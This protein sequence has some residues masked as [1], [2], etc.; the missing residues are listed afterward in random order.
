MGGCG[1]SSQMEVTTYGFK[2]GIPMELFENKL[3]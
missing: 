3:K 1:S 2:P